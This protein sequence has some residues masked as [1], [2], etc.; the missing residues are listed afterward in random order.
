MIENLEGIMIRITM[1]STVVPIKLKCMQ[2][3]MLLI[4]PTT[5]NKLEG[6]TF[7]VCDL[8]LSAPCFSHGQ[9]YVAY[10]RVEKPVYLY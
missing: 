5:I 6:Q 4:F 7:P 3:K 2:L 10:S 9:S 1:I 8:H